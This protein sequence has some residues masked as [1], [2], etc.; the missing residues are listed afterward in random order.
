[1]NKTELINNISKYTNFD[2]QKCNLFLDTLILIFKECMLRGE[3]LCISRFGKFYTYY[4]NPTIHILPHN[5]LPIL[6][7]AKY[8]IKFKISPVFLQNFQKNL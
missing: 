2:K 7:P 5:K 8:N 3:S 1:M 4:Q 6:S